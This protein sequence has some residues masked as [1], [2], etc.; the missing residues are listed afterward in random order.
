MAGVA[1]YLARHEEGQQR[2]PPEYAKI[3]VYDVGYALVDGL[4]PHHHILH[5][6]YEVVEDVGKHGG[7]EL[8]LGA[9]IIVEHG[10]ADARGLG[11]LGHAGLSE[12]LLNEHGLGSTDDL[13]FY[14]LLFHFHDSCRTC[15]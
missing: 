15:H 10:A 8:V 2:F 3:D 9:E 1:M 5:T 7:E 13:L 4:R 12:S 6:G 14:I 11:Y